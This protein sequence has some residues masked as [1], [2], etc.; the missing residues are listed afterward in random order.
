MTPPLLLSLSGSVLHGQIPAQALSNHYSRT[1][2]WGV[3]GHPLTR[4]VPVGHKD[5]CLHQEHPSVT[6]D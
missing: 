2:S 5:G 3:S 6:R 4:L 1:V